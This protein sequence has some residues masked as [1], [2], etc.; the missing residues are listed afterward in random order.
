M[1]CIGDVT[2]DMEVKVLK[3]VIS[4]NLYRRCDWRH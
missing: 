2:G 1:I 4:D 3:P